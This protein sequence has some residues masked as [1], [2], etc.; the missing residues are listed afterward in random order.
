[1]ERETRAF[2]VSPD[3]IL[4]VDIYPDARDTILLLPGFGLGAAS[5]GDFP[6]RLASAGNRVVAVNPRGAGTYH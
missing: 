3:I 5:F 6:R 4:T 2:A 1:M